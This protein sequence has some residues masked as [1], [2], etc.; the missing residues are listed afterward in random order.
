MEQSLEIYDQ[1]SYPQS[2]FLPT[3][4]HTITEQQTIQQSIFDPQYSHQHVNWPSSVSPINE[5]KT[6]GY[7]CSVF[8]TLFPQGSADVLAPRE[9]TVTIVSY[10]KHLMLYHD[11]R[12]AT[13][14]RFR[15]FAL[16]TQ[17]RHQALQTGRI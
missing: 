17:M 16:N 8:P 14:P 10:F 13:H 12:F 6:E 2:T 5:F 3:S 11:Q 15:Y 4:A 9:R 7:I 1:D